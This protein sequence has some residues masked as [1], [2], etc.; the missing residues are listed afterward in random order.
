MQKVRCFDGQIPHLHEKNIVIVI[1]Y[2]PPD[3]NI[4]VFV[5]TFDNIMANI[6]R[7]NKTSFIMG[8]FDIDL[9]DLKN[10]THNPTLEFCGI[11]RV[12][13]SVGTRGCSTFSRGAC[14]YLNILY[15]ATSNGDLSFQNSKWGGTRGGGGGNRLRLGGGACTPIVMPLSQLC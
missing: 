10:S 12:Q 5:D 8:D 2:K 15:P 1:V 6:N 3:I 7:E 4:N 9:I 14:Q 11:T 13:C